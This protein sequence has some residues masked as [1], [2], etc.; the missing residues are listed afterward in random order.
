MIKIS[1]SKGTVV[2]INSDAKKDINGQDIPDS[3]KTD[4]S[5]FRVSS[6]DPSGYVNIKDSDGKTYR[7]AF[8]SILLQ[9]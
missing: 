6:V 7:V 5:T 8:R 3:A 4:N 1:I 9:E 2:K